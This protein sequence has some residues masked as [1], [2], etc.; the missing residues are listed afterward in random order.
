[1]RLPWDQPLVH[2]HSSQILLGECSDTQNQQHLR[3]TIKPLRPEASVAE[4]KG[5]AIWKQ[6]QFEIKSELSEMGL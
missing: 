4:L 3:N 2:D 1:M 6:L 5:F